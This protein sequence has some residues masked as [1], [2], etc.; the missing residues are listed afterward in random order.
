MTLR[1]QSKPHRAWSVF[2]GTTASEIR[3]DVDFRIPTIYVTQTTPTT[4]G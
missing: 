4:G 2:V 3:V 1:H